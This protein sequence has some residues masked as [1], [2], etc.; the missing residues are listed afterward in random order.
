MK[1]N[2]KFIFVPVVLSSF[3]L[4]GCFSAQPNP[5]K[6]LKNLNNFQMNSQNI[7]N[8]IGS[9]FGANGGFQQTLTVLR[10]LK[11]KA[12]S[13]AMTTEYGKK[14]KQYYIK[15]IN[16]SIAD[17]QN[18]A[19][20]LQSKNY[21]RLAQSFENLATQGAHDLNNAMYYQNELQ[22]EVNNAN[23]N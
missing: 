1:I 6:D 5:A 19:Q 12:E 13:L 7:L 2:K 3:F 11:L 21:N 17:L 4:A 20:N 22:N 8:N 16:L 14:A 15:F 9:N 10:N 18:F 23:S